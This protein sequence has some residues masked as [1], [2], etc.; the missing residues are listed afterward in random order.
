MKT[1]P[2]ETAELEAHAEK[3]ADFIEC[4]LHLPDQP[5][6]AEATLLVLVETLQRQH[7]DL[8]QFL[9]FRQNRKPE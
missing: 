6:D 3:L 7:A 9:W 4:V 8:T 1:E 2:E 5:K